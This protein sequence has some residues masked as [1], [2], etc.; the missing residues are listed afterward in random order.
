MPRVTDADVKEILLENY[1]SDNNPSLA[2][3]ITIAGITTD[4][5][6]TK[7][8]AGL[9]TSIIAKEIERWLAAHY[10]QQSDPT[11][12]QEQ[13]ESASGTVLGQGGK[14]FEST[15]FG[16]TAKRL[17]PTGYLTVLDEREGKPTVAGFHMGAALGDQ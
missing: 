8:S 5:L 7:D 10:Y 3:F 14:G 4:M 11:F 9:V 6:L 15:F 13:N 2:H 1:D 12:K 16:Q 17:D